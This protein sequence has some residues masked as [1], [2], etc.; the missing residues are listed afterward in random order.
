MAVSYRGRSHLSK[1]YSNTLF[2]P[3]NKMNFTDALIKAYFNI[4][5]NRVYDLVTAQL[6]LYRRLQ[7]N[8]VNRLELKNN[9]QVLCV[10]V[11]TGNEVSQILQING[12]VSVTG[13]DYSITALKKTNKKA[14]KLGNKVD[15]LL[16]DARRLEFATDSFDKVICIHVM[17]FIEE[18]REVT[19]EILRVLKNEGQFV[20]TYPSDKEGRR[21]GINLVKD[22]IRNNISSSKHQFRAIL[23]SFAQ[24]TVGLV[25]I[26]LLLRPNKKSYSRGELETMITQLTSG[27][28]YIEEDSLYQDFLVCGKKQN[29]GGQ[30]NAFQG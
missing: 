1:G 19:N 8:C 27:K 11:G 18:N 13:V 3:V 29:A 6:S 16:M 15:L 4:A 14:I 7:E 20:I 17:D 23:K 9:D 30:S 2:M 24:M 10:G 21:L 12:N 28:F 5:Y 25:Y 26:P 22:I